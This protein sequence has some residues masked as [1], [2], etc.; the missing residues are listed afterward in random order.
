MKHDD[1][2]TLFRV[3]NQQHTARFCGYEN[4]GL[5]RFLSDSDGSEQWAMILSTEWMQKKEDDNL[6]FDF[7]V[8]PDSQGFFLESEEI[9]KWIKQR[10]PEAIVEIV[11]SFGDDEENTTEERIY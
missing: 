1:E 3:S 9:L 6:F 7:T 11:E 2:I 5:S 10:W 4:S 8:D